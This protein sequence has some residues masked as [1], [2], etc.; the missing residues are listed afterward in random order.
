MKKY[1]NFLLIKE[2]W[3]ENDDEWNE[4]TFIK[5]SHLDDL[6]IMF[7]FIPNK[8]EDTFPGA[9]YYFYRKR[10]MFS[11]Y[12]TYANEKFYVLFVNDELLYEFRKHYCKENDYVIKNIKNILIKYLNITDKNIIEEMSPRIHKITYR[13]FGI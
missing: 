2:A 1:N 8:E 10:L 4:K 13:H 11:L 5:E 3:F 12:T 9:I 7:D 6:F